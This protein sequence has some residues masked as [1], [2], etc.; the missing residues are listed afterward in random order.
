MA[1]LR[2]VASAAL[3]DV[4]EAR[5]AARSKRSAQLYMPFVEAHVA[6]AKYVR[7]NGRARLR[8]ASRRK[9]GGRAWGTTLPA[10]P[11]P[12]PPPP[13]LAEAAA[14]RP[15]IVREETW[16]RVVLAERLRVIVT[17]RAAASEEEE[18]AAAAA[19]AAAPEEDEE[20]ESLKAFSAWFADDLQAVDEEGAASTDVSR[21]LKHP[22]IDK[23]QRVELLRFATFAAGPAADAETADADPTASAATIDGAPDAAEPPTEASANAALR[24]SLRKRDATTRVCAKKKK[25]MDTQRGGFPVFFSRRQTLFSLRVF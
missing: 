21:L 6:L 25:A 18:A 15:L 16:M 2:F 8:M 20:D 13:S 11:K 7:E 14:A 4:L 1:S 12:P 23:R 22:F 5:R 3:V 19:A 9:S 10:P 17:R 24:D